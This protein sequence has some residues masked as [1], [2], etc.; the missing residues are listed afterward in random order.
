[1]TRQE[2]LTKAVLGLRAQ[3]WERSLRLDGA[4]CYDDGN[5][6]RCAWGHVDTTLVSYDGRNVME[7]HQDWVGLAATLSDEQLEFADRVQR[8][9]D[10]NYIPSEMEEGF[11]ILARNNDLTFP[12]AE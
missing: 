7:L 4:C 9:H 6:K 8:C 3:K 2:I 5:G 12:E 10:C 11:R 1:M